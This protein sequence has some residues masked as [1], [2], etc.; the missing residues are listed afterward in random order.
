MSWRLVASMVRLFIMPPHTKDGNKATFSANQ[1]EKQIHCNG[2]KHMQTQ[3]IFLLVFL[4]CYGFESQ[5]MIKD[6]VKVYGHL[7]FSNPW[8]WDWVSFRCI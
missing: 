6:Y 8:Q 5:K 4:Y 1:P 3:I 7:E 2:G